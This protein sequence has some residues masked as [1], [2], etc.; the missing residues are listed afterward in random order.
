MVWTELD[1]APTQDPRLIR[2]AYA[3]RLKSFDPDAEPER[4]QRLRQAYEAALR[5]AGRP[6]GPHA[7]APDPPVETVAAPAPPP[8]VPAADVPTTPE[9]APGPS[10]PEPDRILAGIA[11]RFNRGETVAAVAALDQALQGG[12]L[13]L[14]YGEA[15]AET[16]LMRAIGDPAVPVEALLRLAQRIGWD[17]ASGA[18]SWPAR[19]ARDQLFAASMPRRGTAGSAT[20]PTGPCCGNGAAGA[21]ATRPACCWAGRP[22]GPPGW[23]TGL[24]RCASCWPSTT[25]TPP[26]W[27]GGSTRSG[28][29]GAAA[30]REPG[31]A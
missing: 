21:C 2:R 27:A 25:C 12:A 1:I 7:R 16:V 4:F 30:S 26:G 29:P 28:W 31:S 10:A 11:E 9:S 15:A 3:A 19:R 5:Q 20:S 13:P 23:S 14:G 24:A 18:A 8:P 22:A 17:Q 6:A